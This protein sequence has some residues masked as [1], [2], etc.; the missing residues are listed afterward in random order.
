MHRRNA[1]ERALRTFK[2]HFIAGLCSV[3]KDLPLHLWDRLLPQAE[4][5]LNLLRGSRIN[6]KLSAWAQIHGTFDFNRT[7]IAP[8]G[9]RVLAHQK[10]ANRD[11]WE[12]HAMDGW[13]FGPA[14]HGYRCFRI[15]IWET[16][17][18]RICDTVSLFPSKGSH[19][20]SLIH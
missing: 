2:T 15:W 11:S 6:P 7:P 19:A 18:K 1:A 8:P 10:P 16:R 12:P 14:L 4:L 9:I 5:M 17:T 13:Y 3:D 20:Y